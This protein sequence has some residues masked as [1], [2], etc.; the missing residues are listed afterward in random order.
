MTE[1]SDYDI[2]WTKKAVEAGLDANLQ[3]WIRTR[4]GYRLTVEK[5]SRTVRQFA[6]DVNR[7]HTTIYRQLKAERLFQMLKNHGHPHEGW[8][9]DKRAQ[10]TRN[11]RALRRDL[12]ITIW[13]TVGELEEL[14]EFGPVRAYVYLTDAVYQNLTAPE[15]RNLIEGDNDPEVREWV[16][17]IPL[18]F[19]Q[20]DKMRT[21]FT[22]P[23][24]VQEWAGQILVICGL[25]DDYQKKEESK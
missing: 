14:Y 12:D 19:K 25:I 3:L 9:P 8:R 24:I 23:T 13:A 6:A 21:D 11:L 5:R 1:P 15:I 10:R 16:K 7:H 22:V 2:R 4:I 18:I 20:A 17:R